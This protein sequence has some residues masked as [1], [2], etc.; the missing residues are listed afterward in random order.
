MDLNLSFKSDLKG[1]LT[2][3]LQF[4]LFFFLAFFYLEI[5]MQLLH[6]NSILFL[7]NMFLQWAISTWYQARGWCYVS[8][9]KQ[10]Y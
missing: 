9:E 3:A 5:D 4:W 2:I 1:Y 8:N 7:H 10:T 6:Y